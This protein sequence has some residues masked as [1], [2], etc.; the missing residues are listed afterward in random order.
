MLSGTLPIINFGESVISKFVMRFKVLILFLP[1][2]LVQCKKEQINDNTYFGTKVMII[3]HRGFSAYYLKNPGNT[4]ETALISTNIGADGCEFDVQITKDSVLVLFHD[5]D[6][7]PLTT[8]NG[9]VYN[10]TWDEIKNYKYYSFENNIF[11]NRAD[12]VFSKIPNL[13]NYYFSFDCKV[14]NEN[15]HLNLYMAQLARAI[16]RLCNQYQMTT[17]VFLEG[18]EDFLLTAKAIGLQNKMFL[19]STITEENIQKAVNDSFFGL[20]C[21]LGNDVL[22]TEMAHKN[23]LRIMAYSPKSFNENKL[24]L[25]SNVDIIQ[26]DDP[27]SILKYLNR[28]N[29]SYVIP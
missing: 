13:S 1:F 21:K 11:I 25:K 19:M 24:A 4:I 27:I 22:N 3:G 18:T 2:F 12:S 8:G 17:H 26:S 6:L 29:Y 5:F 16:Q 23:G 20:S 14:D 7:S 10:Y 28:Y 9:K 15:E